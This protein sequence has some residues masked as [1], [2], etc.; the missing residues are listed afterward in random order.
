MGQLEEVWW[1]VHRWEDRVRYEYGPGLVVMLRF[2]SRASLKER[3]M[4][5][6]SGH[7]LLARPGRAVC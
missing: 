6:R 5:T 4:G 3:L 2:V 7:I 1:S